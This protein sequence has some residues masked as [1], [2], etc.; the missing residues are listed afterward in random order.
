MGAA[1]DNSDI[2]A[3]AD[4]LYAARAA[5]AE[6]RLEGMVL[7]IGEIALFLSGAGR[8]LSAAEQ[9]ALLAN[10][11]LRADY[12]RLKSQ[13]SVFELPALAAASDGRIATRRFDG[14][15]IRIHPSRVTGQTYV[16]VHF[17]APDRMPA[18]MVLEHPSGEFMRRALP[19]DR[20]KGEAM[21]LLDSHNPEDVAFLRVLCDPRSTGAF[22]I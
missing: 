19:V 3:R 21:L 11:R 20:A 17:D 9:R 4:A 8:A 12:R 16:F 6:A 5:V 22:L 1:N 18:A 13:L 14:G 15:S 2:A 10:P 7:G